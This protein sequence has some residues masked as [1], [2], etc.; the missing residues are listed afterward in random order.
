M[1]ISNIFT[2]RVGEARSEVTD[3]KPMFVI[4]SPACTDYCSWQTLSGQKYGWPEGRA[5]R[6]MIA[7]D[8]HLFFVKNLHIIF[9]RKF[10]GA[11][12][13]IL[14]AWYVVDLL[15]ST[16]FRGLKFYRCS[17]PSRTQP[18]RLGTPTRNGRRWGNGT[19][20]FK[21]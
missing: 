12:K 14:Q 17:R 3:G 13:V 20:K 1:C 18:E 9:L 11:Y 21:S 8:V 4:G 2:G 16:V 15:G 19:R 6:R 7:S 5:E 10:V